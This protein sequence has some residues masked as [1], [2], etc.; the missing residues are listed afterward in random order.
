MGVKRAWMLGDTPDDI[1][2]ARGAGV[3]PIGVVAPGDDP[4]RVKQTLRH[5]ARVL[6]KI[7]DIEE[8]LP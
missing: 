2:A 5:A 3:V 8:M 7:T 4:T 1:V 6:D